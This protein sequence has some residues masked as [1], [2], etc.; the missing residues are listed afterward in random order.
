MGVQDVQISDFLQYSELE[1][2]EKGE[3]ENRTRSSWHAVIL[4]GEY[5]CQNPAVP[6]GHE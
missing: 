5:R 6:E 4:V 2:F 3:I 1:A